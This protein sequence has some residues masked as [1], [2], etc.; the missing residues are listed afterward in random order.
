MCWSYGVELL[1]GSGGRVAASSS[2]SGVVGKA[3]TA[4]AGCAR[5]TWHWID[6]HDSNFRSVTTNLL[7]IRRNSR[8]EERERE[9]TPHI[10][11]QLS[12]HTQL[13]ALL[14]FVSFFPTHGCISSILPHQAKDV[15]KASFYY[16]Y[17]GLADMYT[18]VLLCCCKIPSRPISFCPK[19]HGCIP[20]KLSQ[21]PQ[22]QDSFY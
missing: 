2:I 11:F 19:P 6:L 12:P 3:E 21:I 9:R 17:Q 15:K 7:R 22:K 8:E 1:T 5:T 10:T 20:T 13:S 16:Y 4:D 18:R 14:Y